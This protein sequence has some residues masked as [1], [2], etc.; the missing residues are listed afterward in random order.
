MPWGNRSYL[1][2]DRPRTEHVAEAKEVVHASL[3]DVEF[4]A[5]DFAQRR[6][7]RGECEAG[8]LL[9]YEQRLDAQRIAGEGQ[10]PGSR[11]QIAA[12]Y[13]PSARSQASSPQRR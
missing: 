9:G 10:G 13:M 7:F 12:A 4:V 8:L 3:V 11:S 2:E 5:R 6:D 1:T